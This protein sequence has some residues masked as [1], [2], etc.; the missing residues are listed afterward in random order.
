M[1]CR[2]LMIT[3][4]SPLGRHQTRLL[5]IFLVTANFLTFISGLEPRVATSTLTVR[6]KPAPLA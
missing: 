2:S 1:L 3:S 6:K 5:V 4:S